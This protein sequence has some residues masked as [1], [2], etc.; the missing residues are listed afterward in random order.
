MDE[1]LW[2]NKLKQVIIDVSEEGELD[3]ISFLFHNSRTEEGLSSISEFIAGSVTRKALDKLSE[4]I[5]E[6]LQLYYKEIV[7]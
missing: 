3:D 7:K 5:S 1:K 2:D 4:S 6:A